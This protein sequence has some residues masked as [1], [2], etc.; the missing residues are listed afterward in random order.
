MVLAWFS[1]A[2]SHFPR[3]PQANWALLVLIP[4]WVGLY[5]LWDPMGLSNTLSCEARSS[6][7]RC[8]PH[9]FFQLEVL[10]LYFPKQEPWVVW[11][12]SLPICSSGL[13][14]HKYGTAGSASC[15]LAHLFC[16]LA[17]SPLRPGCPSLLLLPVRMNVGLP[18]CRVFQ[19]SPPWTAGPSHTIYPVKRG[20]PCH[21]KPL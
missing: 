8:N 5:M 10:G 2:F 12:V 20:P 4:W 7:L 19:G 14:A 16:C 3:Y 6:S 21:P 17:V 11:S 18:L 13:S 15:R 9:R 1:P